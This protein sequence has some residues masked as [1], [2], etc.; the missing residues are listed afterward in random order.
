V[1]VPPVISLARQLA[2]RQEVAAIF[3]GLEE[4]QDRAATEAL[5]ERAVRRQAQLREWAKQRWAR[6]GEEYRENMRSLW[7]AYY[8]RER[9]KKRLRCHGCPASLPFGKRK[10]C[11]R[12]ARKVRNRQWRE[13]KRRRSGRPT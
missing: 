12:C 5:D 8:K 2:V 9:A 3:E 13:C 7:R 6:A 11:E 1:E 10:W 4:E